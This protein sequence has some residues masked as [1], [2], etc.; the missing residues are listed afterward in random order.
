MQSG[1]EG[2]ENEEKEKDP[3][4]PAGPPGPPAS[5]MPTGTLPVIPPKQG[6]R[7][8][9][10]EGLCTAG[11]SLKGMTWDKEKNECA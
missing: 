8:G 10:R 5:V 2:M 7:G 1:R 4:A 3:N 6:F 11:Q 9:R